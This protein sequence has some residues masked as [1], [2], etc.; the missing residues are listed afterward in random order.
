MKDVNISND[1]RQL[2]HG[3]MKA[4]EYSCYDING[5]RFQT[6]KLEVSRPLAATTN[7]VVVR[8]GEDATGHVT[9]YYVILQNIV[10]YK[11]IGTKELRVVFFN[12]IGLIQST[13]LEWMILVWWRSS[14]THTIQL[15]IFCLH[16]RHN[17]C[18]T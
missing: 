10:E 12:V 4:L 5:Y 18:T 6:A 16:I 7:N 1:L 8:S 2:V 9:R 15:A 13:T 3:Q 14:M 17:R 11:F